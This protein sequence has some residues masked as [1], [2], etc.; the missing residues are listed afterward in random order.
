MVLIL[1]NLSVN[2]QEYSEPSFVH[3]MKPVLNLQFDNNEKQST[4]IVGYIHL[5]YTIKL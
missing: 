5:S 3:M 1:N 2:K 4:K